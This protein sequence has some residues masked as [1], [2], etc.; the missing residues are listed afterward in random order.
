MFDR[1]CQPRY[2]FLLYVLLLCSISCYSFV[3]LLLFTNQV[4][5][6]ICSD[7]YVLSL[8]INVHEIRKNGIKKGLYHDVSSTA[9]IF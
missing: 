3:Y 7:F 9:L 2:R 6:I 1:K 4:N 8:Y 5:R